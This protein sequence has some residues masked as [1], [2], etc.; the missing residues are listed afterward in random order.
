MTRQP[1]VG[2]GGV[3]FLRSADARRPPSRSLRPSAVV[4]TGARHAFSH[5][6]VSSVAW[7]LTLGCNVDFKFAG[8]AESSV[9]VWH[10]SPAQNAFEPVRLQR[11]PGSQ[12]LRERADLPYVIAQ[13]YV[14]SA[15]LN[16]SQA[17]A[18]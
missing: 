15:C 16:L 7:F 6:G 11:R 3:A 14:F 5:L 13:I 8:Q 12:N 18:A 4:L 1:C 2:S 10:V 9:D 17:W